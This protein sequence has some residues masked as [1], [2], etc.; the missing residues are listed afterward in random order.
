MGR[1]DRLV[2]ALLAVL[3]IFYIGSGPGPIFDRGTAARRPMPPVAEAPAP[4]QPPPPE[5]VRRPPLAPA[6]PRDPTAVMAGDR[7]AGP[8][9]G[10]AFPVDERGTWMTARHVISG[11]NRIGLFRRDQRPTLASVP[12]AHETADLALVHSE[13]SARPLQFIERRASL[14]DEAFALGYPKGELGAAHFRLLGRARLQHGGWMGGASP[15]LVW[16]DA[17]RFPEELDTLGGMSGG[18][19][20][21]DEGRVIGIVV[22]GSPRRGR[23]LSLAP[24]VLEEVRRARFPGAAS[25]TR[26]V[27]EVSLGPE[28]LR[29]MADSVARSLRIVRVVCDR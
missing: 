23:Q 22:A 3:V 4:T 2:V 15:V 29:D 20:V 11:C 21:D 8:T 25:A 28:R 16:A 7:P 14:E 17:Q 24:E 9:V 5:R 6:S 19:V 1:L 26:P 27:A 13:P 12:F 18:P 10:T